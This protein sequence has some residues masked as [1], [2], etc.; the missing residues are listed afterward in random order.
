MSS[1]TF[2]QRWEDG[3]LFISRKH[4]HYYFCCKRELNVL[5][6][7]ICGT[8]I[9]TWILTIECMEISQFSL[10][11]P[12][13]FMHSFLHYAHLKLPVLILVIPKCITQ[14]IVSGVTF[15]Y[16]NKLIAFIDLSSSTA[17]WLCKFSHLGLFRGGHGYKIVQREFFTHL[18]GM[19]PF[20]RT[21]KCHQKNTA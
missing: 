5:V 16:T 10:V 19:P 2:P 14:N 17:F 20:S 4:E 15:V 12:S 11:D 13:A 8:E 6:C 7:L 9:S 1:F 3:S 21:F 18:T